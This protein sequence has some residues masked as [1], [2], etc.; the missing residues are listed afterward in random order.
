MYKK[1]LLGNYHQQR[2]LQFQVEK[3]P[4]LPRVFSQKLLMQVQNQHF[5]RTPGK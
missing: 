3:Y 4:L 5:H 1:I 2:E